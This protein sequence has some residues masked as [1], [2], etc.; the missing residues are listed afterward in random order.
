M[1]RNR[2]ERLSSGLG[3]TDAI[4]KYVLSAHL[5]EDKY[6]NIELKNKKERRTENQVMGCQAVGRS[7]HQRGM[8]AL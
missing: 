2:L 4:F 5:C 3:H 7:S 6:L 8:S 1:E